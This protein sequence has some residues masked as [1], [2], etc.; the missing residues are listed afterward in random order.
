MSEQHLRKNR[1]KEDRGKVDPMDNRNTSRED[2][3]N[4]INNSEGSS[5]IPS[6]GKISFT[7]KLTQHVDTTRTVQTTIEEINEE[8]E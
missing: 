1:L 6:Q 4:K 3:A 7:E 8:E 5:F 2:N